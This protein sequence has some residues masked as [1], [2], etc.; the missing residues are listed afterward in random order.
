[1]WER[2]GAESDGYV[3]VV[4]GV[5]SLWV[6]GGRFVIGGSRAFWV[7]RE[8]VSRGGVTSSLREGEREGPIILG[9]VS[10]PVRGVIPLINVRGKGRWGWAW[11]R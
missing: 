1:M 9:I 2:D 4:N 11:H 7:T 6:P 10:P 3:T 5:K 8:T